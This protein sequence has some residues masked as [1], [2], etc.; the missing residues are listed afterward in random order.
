MKGIRVVPKLLAI[1]VFWGLCVFNS[2]A[3]TYYV[4]DRAYLTGTY[5]GE[6]AYGFPHGYGTYSYYGGDL[7]VGEFKYN[8]LHGSGSLKF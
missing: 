8:R 4:K 1:V 2:Q 6:V 7:Y 5:S 3:D